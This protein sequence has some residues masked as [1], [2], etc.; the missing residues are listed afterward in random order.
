MTGEDSTLLV[1]DISQI[2]AEPPQQ[3]GGSESGGPAEVILHHSGHRGSV[4]DLQW[5]PFLPWVLASV[6][7]DAAWAEGGGT[8]QIWRPL[9][10]LYRPD[11]ECVGELERL[12][13]DVRGAGD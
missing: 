3:R 6:S 8:L 12:Q 2:G 13:N 7:E 5:N 1:W 11:E 4:Q 10:L 9:D